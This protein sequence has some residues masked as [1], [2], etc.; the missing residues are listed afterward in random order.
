MHATFRPFR[1]MVRV[2]ASSGVGEGATRPGR[3]ILAVR[4][5][6]AL[7]VLAEGSLL[8]VAGGSLAVAAIGAVPDRRA[9]D[10]T[11]ALIALAGG[12]GLLV[13]ARG[14]AGGRAWSRSPVLVWQ[15]LQAATAW[16]AALP[17]GWPMR[18]AL[19]VFA[20]LAGVGVMVPGTV[21][22][23]RR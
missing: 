2:S 8:V 3:T 21:A 10:A 6:V 9:A 14:V 12:A 23:D 19:L 15:L 20:V 4:R 5:A 17:G 18:T 22:M 11:L 16:S 13:V 7:L 1:G